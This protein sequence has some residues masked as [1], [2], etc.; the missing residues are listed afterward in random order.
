MDRAP[1]PD[2]HPAATA[3][4]VERGAGRV[5]AGPCGPVEQPVVQ[6]LIGVAVRLRAVHRRGEG[7]RGH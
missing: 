1:A 3:W 6:I 7:F 4:Q 5:E 2:P